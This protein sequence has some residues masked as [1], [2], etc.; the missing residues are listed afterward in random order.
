MF[1]SEPNDQKSLANIQ[2][3]RHAERQLYCTN[4]VWLRMN[5]DRIRRV[6]CT[7]KGT[8]ARQDRG[9]WVIKPLVRGKAYVSDVAR[10]NNWQPWLYT[11]FDGDA[12]TIRTVNL[13]GRASRSS[14]TDVEPEVLQQS[15]YKRRLT[16]PVLTQAHYSD[17][18]T[19]YLQLCCSKS[20]T[21]ADIR[22]SE[23][24]R[25]DDCDN[26]LKESTN[27]VYMPALNYCPPRKT[28]NP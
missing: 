9:N 4:K 13:D 16:L 25:S 27:G 14:Q 11:A 23:D 7:G 17:R 3:L 22:Q 15:T 6:R 2:R 20:L 8:I 19:Q 10:V 24:S 18:H 28:R 26:T 12:L 5:H 1:G 21:E